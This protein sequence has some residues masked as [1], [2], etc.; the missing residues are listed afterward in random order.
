[1]REIGV[2]CIQAFPHNLW[3][4][5]CKQNMMMWQSSPHIICIT[6]VSM[7]EVIKERWKRSNKRKTMYPFRKMLLSTMMVFVIHYHCKK[8]VTSVTGT[9]NKK[10]IILKT[11]LFSKLCLTTKLFSIQ[12]IVAKLILRCKQL[13]RFCVS[14]PQMYNLD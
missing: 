4:R 11:F 14:N 10:Y 12:T 7:T 13:K 6:R 8:W 3:H 1:M 2:Q 5:G 9:E